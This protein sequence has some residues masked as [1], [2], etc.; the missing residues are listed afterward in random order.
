[1]LSLKLIK[2]IERSFSLVSVYL[3]AIRSTRERTKEKKS[4]YLDSRGE[5]AQKE[6]G[7]IENGLPQINN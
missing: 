4:Y 5:E 2:V 3:F 7:L 1:L 6:P